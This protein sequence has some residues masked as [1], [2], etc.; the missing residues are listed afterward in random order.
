MIKLILII[1]TST[2]A[3]AT[4][5]NPHKVDLCRLQLHTDDSVTPQSSHLYLL[6][7][8]CNLHSRVHTSNQQWRYTVC[9]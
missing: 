3:S 2:I 7:I 5:E 9:I 1:A 4:F 8:L 6:E